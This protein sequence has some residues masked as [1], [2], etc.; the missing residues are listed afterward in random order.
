MHLVE[1][2]GDPLDPVDDDLASG[3]GL[4]CL[5]LLPQELG[6]G[7]VAPEL[8]GLEEIDPAAVRVRLPHQRA[9]AGLA[10]SPQEEAFGARLRKPE[11][12]LEHVLQSSMVV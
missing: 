11:A 7:D 3:R 1:Q 5:E 12:P 4:L 9:L 6:T 10:G 2:R 8:L